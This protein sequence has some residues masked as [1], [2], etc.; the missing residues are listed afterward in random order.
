[1]FC[2]VLSSNGEGALCKSLATPAGYRSSLPCRTD[3]TSLATI[4]MATSPFN[5]PEYTWSG[6]VCDDVD[7]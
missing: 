6:E 7:H 2:D 4:T 5:E 1:M 3:I